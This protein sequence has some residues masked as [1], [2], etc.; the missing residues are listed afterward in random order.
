MR[1]YDTTYV[2]FSTGS[3]VPEGPSNVDAVASLQVGLAGYEWDL[4]SRHAP[5]GLTK[6]S[7]HPAVLDKTVFKWFFDTLAPVRH[8]IGVAA[9]LGWP[10]GLRPLMDGKTPEP[11]PVVGDIVLNPILYREAARFI[12]DLLGIE[13]LSVLEDGDRISKAQAVV[14]ILQQ[15]V[16]A[17]VGFVGRSDRG[18]WDELDT[19][20]I[21]TAPDCAEYE[22]AFV[23]ER[24]RLFAE[25]NRS[26][27]AQGKPRLNRS[28]K[29]ALS[30]ALIASGLD[31]AICSPGRSGAMYIVPSGLRTLQDDQERS[32]IGQTAICDQTFSRYDSSR[33]ETEGF[34]SFP[35][36]ETSYKSLQKSASKH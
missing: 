33:F 5:R 23:K 26:F 35:I 9:P 36:R 25:V 29:Q 2:G 32:N 13:P 19:I 18:K 30:S 14:R 31:S 28:E 16:G 15:R 1:F 21:E 12:H 22:P 20:L 6:N 11:L 8:V 7:L 24:R 10:V 4:P 34:P 27:N 17:H 3:W